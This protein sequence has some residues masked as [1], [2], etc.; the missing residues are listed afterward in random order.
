MSKSEPMSLRE[1]GKKLKNRDL[2]ER[3]RQLSHRDWAERQKKKFSSGSHFIYELHTAIEEII[4][5]RML[6]VG[7]KSVSGKMILLVESCVRTSGLL[8]MSLYF[9]LWKTSNCCITDV[10]CEVGW[11][12]IFFVVIPSQEIT[13]SIKPALYNEYLHP[14]ICRFRQSVMLWIIY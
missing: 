3:E 7:F 12:V 6:D 5:L 8:C 4:C 11:S 10:G 9:F 14:S 2:D 1:V 13:C